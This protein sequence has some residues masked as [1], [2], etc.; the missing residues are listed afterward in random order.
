MKVKDQLLVRKNMDVNEQ[1]RLPNITLFL[2][3]NLYLSVMLDSLSCSFKFTSIS[4]SYYKLLSYFNLY[5]SV[6]L[7][8]LSCS[9][10]F[11]AISFSYYKLF[12]YFNMC[13]S[14]MVIKDMDVN[15]QERLSNTTLTHK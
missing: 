2:Y 8:S 12:F 9:F 13:L 1:E 4:F 14:V 3:L 5:L 7:D 6:M 15:E 10:K 11:T